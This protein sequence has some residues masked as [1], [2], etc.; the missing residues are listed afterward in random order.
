MRTPIFAEAYARSDYADTSEALPESNRDG[1]YSV[2][3][4]LPTPL[5]RIIDFLFFPYGMTLRTKEQPSDSTHIG[6]FS[7]QGEYVLSSRQSIPPNA[8]TVVSITPC[9]RLATQG[10]SGD[11]P[12]SDVFSRN[13]YGSK[14]IQKLKLSLLPPR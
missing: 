10:N 1:F 5:N 4:P 11:G 13:V 9:Q 12:A 3:D 6:T 2:G 8:I 14:T 7:H